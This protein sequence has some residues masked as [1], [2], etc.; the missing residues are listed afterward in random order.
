MGDTICTSCALDHEEQATSA[1]SEAARR[2]PP[3]EDG[4][5]LER[6][7]SPLPTGHNGCPA[8]HRCGASGGA[9]PASHGLCE[10]LGKGRGNLG[11]PGRFRRSMAAPILVI[12]RAHPKNLAPRQ[13][14][15]NV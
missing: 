6:R 9:S 1:L 13:P 2:I 7:R 10:A 8:A 15:S 3:G 5:L 11:G 4:D 14:R 12:L